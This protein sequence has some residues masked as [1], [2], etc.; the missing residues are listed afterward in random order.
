MKCFNSFLGLSI[1]TYV[2]K[3]IGVMGLKTPPLNA[4]HMRRVFRELIYRGVITRSAFDTY[5]TMPQV[6]D[7][8]FHMPLADNP[9]PR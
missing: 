7:A 1:I 8:M 5:P 4:E 3:F 6:Q 9:P 2:G